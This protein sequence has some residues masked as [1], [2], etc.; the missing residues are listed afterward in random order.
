VIGERHAQIQP[1][2]EPAAAALIL[3]Q[4]DAVFR[5]LVEPAVADE[6]EYVE[7]TLAP[8][9]PLQLGEGRL[10]EP[11]DLDRA[12]LDEV[13]ERAL[14]VLALSLHVEGRCVA[15]AANHREDAERGCDR[16]GLARCREIEVPNDRRPVGDREEVPLVVEEL[17]RQLHQLGHLGQREGDAE[18]LALRLR[19]AERLVVEIPDLVA[20][21]SVEE[22]PPEVLCK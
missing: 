7:W 5:L 17:P 1:T 6:V 11:R 10:L 3:E 14:E 12:G 22:L 16:E 21:E 2:D 20:K 8:E 13:A 19:P 18:T 15:R 9:C 4:E